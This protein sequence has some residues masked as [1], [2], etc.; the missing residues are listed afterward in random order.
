MERDIVTHE[1]YTPTCSKANSRRISQN[2]AAS[3]WLARETMIRA[4]NWDP[5]K[6]GY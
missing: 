1:R 3:L 5:H 6:E 4:F 2:A